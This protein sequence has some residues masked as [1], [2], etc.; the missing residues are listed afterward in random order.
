ML[1]VADLGLLRANKDELTKMENYL[2]EKYGKN[3]IEYE[4][5]DY[6]IIVYNGSFGLAHD[7]TFDVLY[8]IYNKE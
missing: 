6:H 5:T 1:R 4:V 3:D 7:V 2:E 8:D